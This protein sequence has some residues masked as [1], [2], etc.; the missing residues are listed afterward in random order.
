MIVETHAFKEAFVK[1]ESSGFVV[2]TDSPLAP[3]PLFAEI[4]VQPNC[5]H[6]FETRRAAEFQMSVAATGLPPR[7]DLTIPEVSV[8]NIRDYQG[9]DGLK[10]I[11]LVNRDRQATQSFRVGDMQLSARSQTPSLFH[12]R[13]GLP[14]VRAAP[15][16]KAFTP[17]SPAKEHCRTSSPP[18]ASAQRQSGN[19]FSDNQTVL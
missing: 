12:H 13:E 1:G 19:S 15:A 8:E 5:Y 17:L 18:R 2:F 7:E 11:I 10:T 6:L 4:Y 14:V 16:Q 3:R 9:L